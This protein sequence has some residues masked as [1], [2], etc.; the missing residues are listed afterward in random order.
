MQ[1][2]T[3]VST[4]SSVLFILSL[5]ILLCT[6]Y[7]P[8]LH[9]IQPH[10]HLF[11]LQLLYLKITS[12]SYLSLKALFSLLRHFDRSLSFITYFPPFLLLLFPRLHLLFSYS[13]IYFSFY[14]FLPFI[15]S[16]IL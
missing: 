15:Y 6:P 10:L 14:I 2:S 9:L 12:L 13:Y 8:L 16:K 3:L 11:L 4:F 5:T 1:R 7:L